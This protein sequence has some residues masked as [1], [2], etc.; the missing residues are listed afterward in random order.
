MKID[1]ITS[2]FTKLGLSSL[3]IDCFVEL[4]KKSP[5]KASELA[6]KFALPKATVLS[7]LYH[8]SDEKG[9]IKRTKIKN[10]FHFLVEDAASVI[11]FITRKE[12]I[13]LENKRNLEQLL[14]ELR[15][16]QNLDA[17]KPKIFYYEGRGGLKQAFEQVLEE[18]DEI[19]GYGSNEDDVK[20]LPDL[21]PSYYERRVKKKIPVK[22][23]I[24]GTAFN[25]QE[26]LKNEIKHLRATHL[27]PK[28]FNY[29]IQINIYRHTAIFYSF[30]ESF[31]LVIKSRPIADCLKK[32]F[33]LA[34]EKADDTDREIR[35]LM[36]HG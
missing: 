36:K 6:K 18:A 9:L 24:P 15:A 30:E 13:L 11:N 19:I 7:A 16:M 33:E 4:L 23:I 17:I 35:K 20:Y 21:Y 5:Q 25:L 14:P 12:E 32:I 26:T 29:P 10:S 2:V 1:Q 8:L 31:G 22:A 34:F 27:I 28:E 3:E